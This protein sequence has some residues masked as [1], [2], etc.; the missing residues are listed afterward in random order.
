[1]SFSLRAL[2]LLLSICLLTSCGLKGQLVLTDK[3]QQSADKKKTEAS[4]SPLPAE[5]QDQQ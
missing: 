2:V 4:E 5:S 3:Q 1:M